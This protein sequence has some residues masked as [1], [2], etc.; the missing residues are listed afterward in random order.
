MILK[1]I[2]FVPQDVKISK[3]TKATWTN[4]DT[5]S[6]YVNTDSHPAHTYQLNQNSEELRQGDS[7]TYTFENTGIYPYHCSA[8]AVTMTANI[9]VE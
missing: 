3:G 4:S 7:F 1:N 2:A 9:L 5:V 8:H 6:H